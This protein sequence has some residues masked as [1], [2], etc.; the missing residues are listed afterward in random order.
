MSNIQGRWFRV[1]SLLLAGLVFSGTSSAQ[2]KKPEK[3]PAKA[4]EATKSAKTRRKPKGRLPAYYSRV[5]N[6]VQREKIYEVQADFTA[7]IEKLM[8]EVNKLREEMSTA[9][10]NVLSADQRAQVEE[11]RNQARQRRNRKTTP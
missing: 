1:L 9:V 6:A 10:A 7:K 8:A 11:F 4:V 5:V 3:S 2:E